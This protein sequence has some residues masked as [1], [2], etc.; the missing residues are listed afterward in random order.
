MEQLFKDRLPTKSADLSIEVISWNNRNE[1][2]ASVHF[3][4]HHSY[5]Q[6]R[7]HAKSETLFLGKKSQLNEFFRTHRP[8]YAT[9]SRFLP[10]IGPPVAISALFS[11]ALLARQGSVVA[12]LLSGSL[13][14][15]SAAAFWLAIVQTL[16]PYVRV[17]L[18]ASGTGRSAFERI[19]LLVQVLLLIATIISILFPLFVKTPR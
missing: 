9:V 8:W 13:A 3:D 16:F 2:E 4:A 19:T 11:A 6:Y 5:A 14:L 7:I 1:I 17:Q 18:S 15:V 10:M 12:A